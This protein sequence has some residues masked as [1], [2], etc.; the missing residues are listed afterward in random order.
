MEKSG[1]VYVC[2]TYYHVFV[3]FLK[4]L[5]LANRVEPADLIISTISTD[6]EDFKERLPLHK[7]LLH[8]LNYRFYEGPL[9]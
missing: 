3:S 1:R 4:E 8:R 9:E 2:H 7:E 6:F 5:N